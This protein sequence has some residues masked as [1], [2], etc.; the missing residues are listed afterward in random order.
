M[1]I[2]KTIRGNI[3]DSTCEAYVCP[4]NCVGILGAG[5]AKA[6]RDDKRFEGS[7]H[8]YEIACA[9]GSLGLGSVWLGVNDLE[10]KNGSYVFYLATKFHWKDYSNIETVENSLINLEKAMTAFHIKSCAVPLIGAGLG[11]LSE[12]RV[13]ATIKEIF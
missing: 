12:S 5:L 2:V 10:A 13:W 1:S 6:F 7:N 9:Q 8:A 4:S 11:M 3:F